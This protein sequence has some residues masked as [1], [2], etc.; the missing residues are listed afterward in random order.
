M[1]TAE[2]ST[3]EGMDVN[4]GYINWVQQGLGD[5]AGFVNG[6]C[7][8]AT[9]LVDLPVY[10]VLASDYLDQY[11]ESSGGSPAPRWVRALMQVATLLIV[12]AANA[13]GAELVGWLSGL[14]LVSV[15]APFAVMLFV[16]GLRGDLDA[17]S[18]GE[19][20]QRCSLD[21]IDSYA[22]CTAAGGTLS[23]H[24]NFGTFI[25]TLLWSFS[26]W[27]S[28][29]CVAGEVRNPRR[30][31]TLGILLTI[32]MDVVTYFIP[33]IV[34]AS[35]S[36]D[37]G[38]WSDGYFVQSAHAVA[39]WMGVW[40]LVAAVLSS[41]GQYNSVMCTTSR[42]LWAMGGGEETIVKDSMVPRAFG[43]SWQ[44]YN[45]PIIA[46]LFQTATTGILMNFDFA[47]LVNLNVFLNNITLVLE[48]LAFCAFRWYEPERRRPFSVPWGW[49]GVAL[50]FLPKMFLIIFA[51]YVAPAVVWITGVAFVAATVTA[52]YARRYYRRRNP[53]GPGS[54]R[55]NAP[56][57]ASRKTAPDGTPHPSPLEAES[58]LISPSR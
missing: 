21:G 15:L 44:R 2:L 48:S 33:I 37:F 8:F 25:S 55:R 14:L 34:A 42:A 40:V 52:Y 49:Y 36:K 11:L 56:S 12:L 51:F 28:L 57:A 6:Y 30:T 26:G 39:P 47:L 24:V 46:I 10:V 29:G 41:L 23:T 38:L 17:S 27:D 50:V 54:V 3:M 45:T 13:R 20:A 19:V 1:M 53:G 16:V 58:P 9:N 18:W 31:Y 35:L 32:I 7:C 4:G 43:I 22:E 5:A